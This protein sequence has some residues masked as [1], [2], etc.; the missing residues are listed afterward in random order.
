MTA[1]KTRLSVAQIKELRN[2]YS[3][4]V[5]TYYSNVRTPIV[6]Q[7]ND[8]KKQIKSAT[9]GDIYK[10]LQATGLPVHER[11]E[12]SE[13]DLRDIMKL[14]DF[15]EQYNADPIITSCRSQEK[16]ICQAEKAKHVELEQWFMDALQANTREEIPKFTVEIIPN[17]MEC[18]AE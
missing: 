12:I 7:K 15:D 10:K 11:K 4:K 2:I 5:S 6:A 14:P 18:S 17:P 9:Y 16:A 1:S 13:G 8:R 3:S